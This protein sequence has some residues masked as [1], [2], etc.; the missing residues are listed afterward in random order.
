M[1]RYEYLRMK[2]TDF[3]MHVQQQYNIHAHAKIG[4]IYLEIRGGI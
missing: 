1:D 3:P 4:Y 2:S